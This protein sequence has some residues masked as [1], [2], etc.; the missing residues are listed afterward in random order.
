MVKL[1]NLSYT[2][3]ITYIRFLTQFT[4]HERHLGNHIYNANKCWCIWTSK[5]W[6]QKVFVQISTM[7]IFYSN[8][9][10]Y[11]N[12]ILCE[13][14]PFIWFTHGKIVLALHSHLCKNEC[15]PSIQY[16]AYILHYIG[17]DISFPT[18]GGCEG[19][20]IN[21]T[22]RHLTTCRRTVDM[23]LL[24]HVR[25]CLL[26]IRGLMS[27]RKKFHKKYKPCQLRKWIW[28]LSIRYRGKGVVVH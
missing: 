24:I 7:H 9:I 12:T 28:K 4:F 10:H 20:Q 15:V 11:V 3:R 8:S 5:Y 2:L 22:Y 27:F 16:A 25:Q 23:R 21:T 6:T 17:A 26:I 18:A 1:S 14:I 13:D 19:S